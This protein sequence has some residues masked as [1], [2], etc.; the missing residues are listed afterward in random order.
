T[1]TTTTTTPAPTTVDGDANGDGKVLLSDAVLILQWL[2]NHDE[3]HIA[4]AQIEAADVYERG[5]GLTSMDA[6]TIQ[7][8]LLKLID[9]LPV[10]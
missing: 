9:S 5:S 1:T 2:G 3:Y 8:F 6:L 7:K 10:I 4:E